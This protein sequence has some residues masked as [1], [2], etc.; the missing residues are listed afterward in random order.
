[1]SKEGMITTDEMASCS[2]L[3]TNTI[4]NVQKNREENMDIDTGISVA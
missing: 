4:R 1:M 3:S 2:I